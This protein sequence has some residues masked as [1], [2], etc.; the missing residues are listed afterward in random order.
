M[1]TERTEKFFWQ[2]HRRL[3]D[4]YLHMA[5]RFRSSETARTHLLASRGAA[6][7]AAAQT[8]Y[9][10]TL[11]DRVQGCFE[12]T[13]L[14]AGLARFLAG[15]TP[16]VEVLPPQTEASVQQIARFYINQAHKGAEYAYDF[17]GGDISLAH[18]TR[19]NAVL[20]AGV[21]TKFAP[22]DMRFRTLFDEI[23][24]VT[25]TW[26]FGSAIVMA[27]P[28]R[29]TLTAGQS[30]TF[31]ADEVVVCDPGRFPDDVTARRTICTYAVPAGFKGQITMLGDGA[32][33]DAPRVREVI[34][35]TAKNNYALTGAKWNEFAAKLVGNLTIEWASPA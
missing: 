5:P 20:A 26:G 12:Q 25:L 32:D 3:F 7:E 2:L 13:L 10:A 29:R 27:G 18:E 14:D 23:N 21:D 28:D 34:T 15:A 8:N 1:T 22:N 35:R 33:S 16:E 31:N 24:N 6:H 11:A 30:F 17:F 9:D 4:T 19:I